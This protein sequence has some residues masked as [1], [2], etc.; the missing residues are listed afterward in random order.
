MRIYD[1][2]GVLHQEGS[3]IFKVKNGYPLVGAEKLVLGPDI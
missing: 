3:L 1:E 2:Y